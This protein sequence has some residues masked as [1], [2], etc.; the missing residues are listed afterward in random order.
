MS[1]ANGVHETTTTSGT[2]DLTLV[3]SA[4]T[5]ELRFSDIFAVGGAVQW[6]AKSK[7]T[8]KYEEGYGEVGASNTLIRTKPTRQHDGTS[9]VVAPTTPLNFAGE[10]V[11]VWAQPA[12]NGLH[13]S[14]WWGNWPGASGD[15]IERNGDASGSDVGSTH[16]PGK[17]VLTLMPFRK[18]SAND[19]QGLVWH[20]NAAMAGGEGIEAY[21]I[22][23][24][25]GGG[26]G[27]LLGTV[28]TTAN[29]ASGA[30][31]QAFD[32][33]PVIQAP[34]G[35]YFV[36]FIW[37]YATGSPTVRGRET[38]VGQSLGANSNNSY[39]VLIE[40]FASWALGDGYPAITSLTPATNDGVT[41][42]ISLWLV[43]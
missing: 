26:P 6:V 3:A 14:G 31:I 32:G 35:E 40:T 17:G 30:H 18:K 21:F 4:V 11:D 41:V 29:P 13:A 12:S 20:Q 22:A 42:D 36:G 24:A 9:I 10:T 27:Q 34:P 19:V 23:A 5:G 15:L 37:D 39:A 28:T 2:G 43:R 38:R 33:S 16:T 25:P 1:T 8:A 7:T